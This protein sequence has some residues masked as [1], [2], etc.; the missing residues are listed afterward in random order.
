MYEMGQKEEKCDRGESRFGPITMERVEELRRCKAKRAGDPVLEDLIEA[1]ETWEL[2]DVLVDEA[3]SAKGM[4]IAIGRAAGKRGFAVETFESRDVAGNAVVTVVRKPEVD[5]APVGA[6]GWSVR[7]QAPLLEQ[8]PRRIGP[9]RR[10]LSGKRGRQRHDAWGRGLAARRT[11][12]RGR[13]SPGG[14]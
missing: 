4:R 14:S 7:V 11:D 5:R 13:A 6:D 12:P 10:A 2:Q 9:S 8:P 1:V 3:S